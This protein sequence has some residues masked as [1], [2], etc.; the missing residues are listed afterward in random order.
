MSD[1]SKENALHRLVT[2]GDMMGDGL[3]C[4]PGGAWITKEYK[5]TLKEAGIIPTRNYNPDKINEFMQKRVNE[6]KCSC[7]GILKQTRKGSF[8]A[9]CILC[10]KLWQLGHKK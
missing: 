3:H 9:S 2:L 5:R 10:G 4:E 1:T 8:R 7:G 6:I